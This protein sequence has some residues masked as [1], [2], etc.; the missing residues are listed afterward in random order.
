MKLYLATQNKHKIDEIAMILAPYSI[1]VI[2][3]PFKKLELQSKNIEEIALKAVESIE[4]QD[5]PVAVEDSGLFIDE[6][7]GFPGPYS[8]YVYETIGIKG[9][10]KLMQG[11]A[12]RS[13]TFISV[14][15]VK[16]PQGEIKAFKGETKGTV[17]LQPRGKHGFGFD[18]IFQPLGS[19][20]TFAEMSIEE[21]NTYSHRGKAAKMLAGWLRGII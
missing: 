9:V 8:S 11:V 20:K 18:P 21:K 16:T 12:D 19:N 13:A 14:I 1:Q 3:A 2:A 6:L 7:N 5:A 17:T 10:L 15:A 4:P